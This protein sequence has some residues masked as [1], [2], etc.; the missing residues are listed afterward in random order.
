VPGATF[1]YA[2]WI[3]DRR[4]IVGVYTDA[5]GASHGF[6]L[7]EGK[8]ITLDMPGSTFTHASGINNDGAIV[9][10]FRV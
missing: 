7:S 3:N 10:R 2:H 6:L 9:G 1:T 4:Q 8:Y 5:G